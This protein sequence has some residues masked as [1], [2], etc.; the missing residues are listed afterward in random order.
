MYPNFW[1]VL[2]LTWVSMKVVKKTAS[3]KAFMSGKVA[4]TDT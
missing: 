3:K 1:E 4:T 2:L